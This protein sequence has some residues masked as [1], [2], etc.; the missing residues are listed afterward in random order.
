MNKEDHTCT[1][2]CLKK[3]I[4][5]M[6]EENLDLDAPLEISIGNKTYN[7]EHIGHFHVVPNLVIKLWIK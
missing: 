2:A 1:T 5:Q 3:A 6:E 7:V 4:E